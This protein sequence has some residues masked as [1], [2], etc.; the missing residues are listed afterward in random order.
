MIQEIITYII[1]AAA[2]FF[3]VYKTWLRFSRKRKAKKCATSDEKLNSKAICDSCPT[4]CDL[5]QTVS[6]QK[7]L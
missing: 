2:V 7:Q 4:G 3:A 5:K 1:V 6:E